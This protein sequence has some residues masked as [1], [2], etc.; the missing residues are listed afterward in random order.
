MEMLSPTPKAAFSLLVRGFVRFACA[1]SCVLL[2]CCAAGTFKLLKRVVCLSQYKVQ[3]TQ[4]T[5]S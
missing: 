2:C 1:V 4:A 3:F 5:G